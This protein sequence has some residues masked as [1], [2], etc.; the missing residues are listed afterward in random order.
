MLLVKCSSSQCLHQQQSMS[1]NHKLIL[2]VFGKSTQNQYYYSLLRIHKYYI[3]KLSY[4]KQ[5]NVN[6]LHHDSKQHLRKSKS[7]PYLKEYN[8]CN[9]AKQIINLLEKYQ[10]ESD[11]I[12]HHI[13]AIQRLAAMKEFKL[14]WK[15][16]DDFITEPRYL[17]SLT[18]QFY[19]TMIWLSCHQHMSQPDKIR[20]D[21][22]RRKKTC[23]KIFSLLGALRTKSNLKIDC[24]T[25][26]AVLSS[27]TKLQ[28]FGRGE[29]F[30]KTI[31]SNQYESFQDIELNIDCYNVML[32]LYSKSDQMNEAYDL[33]EN[34]KLSNNVPFDHIT[35]STLISGCHKH[36]D[37]ITAQKIFDE[38]K[39]YFIDKTPNKP[40]KDVYC[41]LMNGYA[42]RGDVIKCWELFVEILQNYQNNKDIIEYEP[43]VMP[44]SVMLKSL[45]RLNNNEK[46]RKKRNRNVK[47][48]IEISIEDG[49]KL[50]IDDCW[51]MIKYII[52][53]MKELDIKRNIVIYGLLFHL[54]GDAFGQQNC[55]Y[56]VAQKFYDQMIDD[57]IE[58]SSLCFHNFLKVGLC[59]FNNIEINK[60][61]KEAFIKWILTEMKKHNVPISSQTRLTLRYENVDIIDYRDK[62]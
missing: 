6:D 62:E 15:I 8:D 26:T 25:I 58:I 54:C 45:A 43:D 61:K 37:M 42:S 22:L 12:R 48:F 52:L 3:H 20:N 17:S 44:F 30:W 2:S 57:Q 32:N 27:C 4:D 56:N 50:S 14:C 35:F 11:I 9:S 60:E 23:D 24:D 40:S 53:K 55:K 5:K 10:D 21:R 47:K 13:W 31:H 7:S 29:G 33:Y 51:K 39:E 38:A 49:E 46:L 19:N 34:L 28:Q 36:G 41:A 16:F 18:T 59:H 1:H